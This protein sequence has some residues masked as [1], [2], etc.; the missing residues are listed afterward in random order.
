[1]WVADGARRVQTKHKQFYVLDDP[2]SEGGV[3]LFRRNVRTTDE[4]EPRPARQKATSVS[5]EVVFFCG[6]R[7]RLNIQ[8]FWPKYKV[9]FTLSII[10]KT[11]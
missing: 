7:L 4:E 10:V 6:W 8:S 9:W 5:T 1:L 3:S 11:R 2:G